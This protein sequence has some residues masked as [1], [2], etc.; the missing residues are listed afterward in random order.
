MQNTHIYALNGTSIHFKKWIPDGEVLGSIVLIHGLGEHI[1]RYQ[2]VAAYFNQRNIAVYGFDLPGHGRS[3]GKRGHID[4]FMS[5]YE[6][7]NQIKAGINIENPGKSVF[8]Y[9]HSLG[10][11]IALSYLLKTEPKI[12]GLILSAPG[13]TNKIKI[14][15]FKG[16]MVKLLSRIFPDFIILTNL[17]PEL[18]SRDKKIVEMY[19]A[20]PLV[21]D[22]ASVRLGNESITTGLNILKA[23]NKT[24][25]PVLLIQGTN[26]QIVP[27]EPN[28]EFANKLEGNIT[29]KL[30]DGLYHEPHNEPE[31]EEVFEYTYEW[32]RGL[33]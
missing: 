23:K 7:I 9:G 15:K 5:V 26:D 19:K 3:G 10:G 18:L 2:H 32:L 8:V 31:K 13:L 12:D 24:E 22:K 30:W 20:D 25:T 17:D 27:V 1:D 14:S 28:V 16:M 33:L 6:I 21:H 29:V 4:S 11:L